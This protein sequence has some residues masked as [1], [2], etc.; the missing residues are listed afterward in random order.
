M[1]TAI[2]SDLH[3]GSLKGSDLARLPEVGERLAAALADAD[4][5]IVLGDLLELRERPVA[6]V[7]ELARPFVEAVGRATAGRRVTVLPGNHDH[8]LV[9]PFLARERLEG[10]E[11][12]PEHEWPVAPRDG[13]AGRLAEWM[14][15]TELVLAYPGFR[16]RPD[17]YVTHGHYLDARLTMPRLETIA[18]SA[19]ARLTGRRDPRSAAEFEAIV[20]PIY[21]FSDQIAQGSTSAVVR[22]STEISRDV[23]SRVNG[24]SGGAGAF[25]LRRLAIPGAVGALNLAGL[26][27][28]KA[29]I[30]GE[31]LRRSGLD[32]MRAVLEA[33]RVDAK[34][35]IFGHTHRAGPLPDDHMAEWALPGGGTLHNTG[36]WFLEAVFLGEN[37]ERSP[38][39][40]GTVTYLGESGPPTLER[41][42]DSALVGG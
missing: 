12:G 33:V 15:D 10:V 31:A 24:G 8:A 40:P 9:A 38:Y 41:V 27:P 1:R 19:V 34:H 26:G 36:S 6:E 37:P 11:L 5:A 28:F 2:V 16:P 17:V 22:S 21:A 18:A 39:F 7:L 25:V 14:P 32:A 4:H 42:L 29:E 3:L 20:A 30:T 13:V 35:V 23:W